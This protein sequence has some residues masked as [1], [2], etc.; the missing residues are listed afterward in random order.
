[1]IRKKIFLIIVSA[2]MFACD[3]QDS[4]SKRDNVEQVAD[5]SQ[6]L[7]ENVEGAVVEEENPMVEAQVTALDFY[8][9][10]PSGGFLKIIDFF[11]ENYDDDVIFKSMNDEGT[12]LGAEYLERDLRYPENAFTGSQFLNIYV[13]DN[14]DGTK[15]VFLY[16]NLDCGDYDEC[17]ISKYVYRND[18]LLEVDFHKDSWWAEWSE[19]SKKDWGI[20]KQK[21]K[22]KEIN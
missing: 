6:I 18:S 1:M 21:C 20:K 3:G 8:K 7:V 11:R 17:D 4:D 10:I 22:I 19:V 13:I 9:M 14:E 2:L 16:E 15:T 5:T 12:A